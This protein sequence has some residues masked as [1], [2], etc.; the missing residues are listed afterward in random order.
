MK[1][2]YHYS[3]EFKHEEEGRYNVDWSYYPEN[4]QR[5]TPAEAWAIGE[6]RMKDRPYLVIILR[7]WEASS[8][9]LTKPSAG[10]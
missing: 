9:E 2:T 10:V 4:G 7:V 8:V 5:L 6:Q 3:F 1:P